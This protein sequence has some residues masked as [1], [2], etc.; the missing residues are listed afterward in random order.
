MEEEQKII[1]LENEKIK[2]VFTNEANPDEG[3]LSLELTLTRDSNDEKVTTL[4]LDSSILNRDDSFMG[5]M[6]INTV[7]MFGAVKQI[8]DSKEIYKGL[9]SITTD[10]YKEFL[11]KVKGVNPKT[12]GPKVINV[13]GI[14]KKED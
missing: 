10:E 6:Y 14:I 5:E 3:S 4:V 1:R 7:N 11:I 2:V 9:H 8:F 12:F 13:D